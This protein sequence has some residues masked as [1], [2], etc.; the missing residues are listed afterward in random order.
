M[1][2]AGIINLRRQKRRIKKFITNKKLTPK[3]IALYIVGG[4]F[5]LIVIAFL[6]NLKD[7]PTPAKLAKLHQ[8]ESTKLVDRNGKTLYETGEERR[9]VLEQKNIPEIVKQ[10]T[11][12][13]EDAN[14][15]KH[16]G[17][18][19]RG[20][21]RA[22]LSDILNLSLSQGGS[23][24]TQQFVKNALLSNEKTFTRKRL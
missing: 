15:Y 10:A 21:G 24:I 8:T 3:K 18:D 5:A 4:I 9:T 14:F 7:L 16:S 22:A 17:V 2:I 6:W 20:I 13:A 12:S 1:K 23:T 19:F 11:I